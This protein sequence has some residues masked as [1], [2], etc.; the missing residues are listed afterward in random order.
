MNNLYT[1][2]EIL[3]GLGNQLFQLAYM[4]YFLRLSKKQKISNLSIFAVF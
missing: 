3:G 4:I 1:S 2:V